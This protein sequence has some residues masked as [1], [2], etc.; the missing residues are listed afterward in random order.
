MA[1]EKPTIHIDTDWKKQAQEEKRRLVE[2][3][4]KS[5]PAVAPAPAVPMASAAAGTP[6]RRTGAG[7]R[8]MPP[9][10]FAALV[11]SIMTQILFY[12]GEIATSSGGGGVDLDM[13]KY[14]LDQLG[15]LE[16]KTINNLTDGEKTLLDAALY[17]T[18][19]RFISVASQFLGP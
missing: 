10:G 3:A 13:A 18:R 11:Q 7:G 6:G 14:Q 1:D 16:E 12:L 15:M 5:T 8:E 17:E 2:E 19:S 9:P 4:A